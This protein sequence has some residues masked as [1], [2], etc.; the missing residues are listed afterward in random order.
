MT[1]IALLVLSLCI[2][3]SATLLQVSVSVTEP[4]GDFTPQ[5]DSNSVTA[6]FTLLVTG[7]FGTAYWTPILELDGSTNQSNGLDS[8]IGGYATSTFPRFLD[9][10]D[11]T[12]PAEGNSQQTFV[13]NPENCAIPFTFGVEENF[14]ITLGAS[15]EI[16]PNSHAPQ[17]NW[18][19][20]VTTSAE[21]DGVLTF[22]S[23][24]DQFC[25][26]D[27]EPVV[28][29]V[30]PPIGMPESSSFGFVGMGILGLGVLRFAPH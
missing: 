1:R 2:P 8:E 30:D 21:F 12:G 17:P 5:F 26:L 29:L 27:F 18:P 3:L 19:V 11:P 20:T 15:A 10:G 16:Q 4:T 28:S 24:P 14:Q 7:G 22:S 9:V 13:C 25:P 6:D 23:C